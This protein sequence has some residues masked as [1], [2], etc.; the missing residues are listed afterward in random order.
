MHRNG[1]RVAAVIVGTYPLRLLLGLD[2]FLRDC[3]YV[4]AA[5]KNLI[6]ISCL[7]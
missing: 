6:S 1:A 7:A 2:L 3:Y 5:S 4:P